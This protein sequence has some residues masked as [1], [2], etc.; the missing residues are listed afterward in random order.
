MPGVAAD[1]YDVDAIWAVVYNNALWN[2]KL[3]NRQEVRS[4]QLRWRYRNHYN[5]I[6]GYGPP[7]SW[8]QEP[9]REGHLIGPIKPV[10][11]APKGRAARR[12]LARYAR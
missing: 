8:L 10:G 3:S 12:F 6:M 4:A 1:H 5:Y 7:A 2:V 9:R 11:G